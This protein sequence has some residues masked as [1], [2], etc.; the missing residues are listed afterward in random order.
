MYA[1]CGSID[2]ARLVFDRLYGNIEIDGTLLFMHDVG[3]P[4]VIT[5]AL[6]SHL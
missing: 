3:C 2:N 1:K 5:S 4:F 6:S